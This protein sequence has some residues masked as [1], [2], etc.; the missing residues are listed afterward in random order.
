M[1][2]GKN[3]KLAIAIS[4]AVACCMC[5]VVCVCV[6]VFNNFKSGGVITI[7]TFIGTIATLIGVCVTIMLGV[8]IFNYLEF[9]DVKEKIQQFKKLEASISINNDKYIKM[10]ISS[11][12]H[13]GNAFQVFSRQENNNKNNRIFFNIASIVSI[14][15]IFNLTNDENK[16]IGIQN[17][18]LKRLE[19]MKESVKG[20]TLDE[21]KNLKKVIV[22]FKA[23]DI[24]K[25]LPKYN[26]I[27]NIY[28][29]IV[30]KF[31]SFK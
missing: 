18:L 22:S 31:E 28:S 25:N 9:Q 2:K 27:I 4:G 19:G 26:E 5:C 12:T 1:C 7:D 16:K 13:I 24:P 15:P 17:I 23:I 10:H 20:M 6:V 14:V 29:E 8:Q 3:R 11:A 21:A 30:L